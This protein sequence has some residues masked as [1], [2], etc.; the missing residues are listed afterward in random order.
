M[1]VQKVFSKGMPSDDGLALK[2]GAGES[3]Q[4]GKDPLSSLGDLK[5]PLCGETTLSFP[6]QT[7]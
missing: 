2:S 6:K 4:V 3:N 5:Q 7:L 1:G